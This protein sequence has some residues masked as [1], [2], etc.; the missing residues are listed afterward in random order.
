MEKTKTCVFQANCHLIWAVKY[1]RKV[2]VGPVEVKLL[3]VLKAIADNHGYRLLTARVHGGDHVHVFVSASQV[4]LL[5][6]L[7]VF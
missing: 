1:R 6:V 5:L 4:F 7:F 2:L 3:D